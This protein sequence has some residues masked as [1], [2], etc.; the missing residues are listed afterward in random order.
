MTGGYCL[1]VESL[2]VSASAVNVVS[3][4]VIFL[5]PQALIWRLNMTTKRKIAVSLIFFIAIL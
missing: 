2:N 1:N 4:T 3:D 5:L